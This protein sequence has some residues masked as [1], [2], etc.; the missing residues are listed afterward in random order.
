MRVLG[1][2]IKGKEMRVALVERIDCTA[3]WVNLATKKIPLND[4]DSADEMRQIFDQV[5][6]LLSEH[7]VDCVAVKKRP[8][9]GAM[10]SGG[11]SFRLEAILQLQTKADFRLVTAQRI[12]KLK[13]SGKVEFPKGLNKYQHDAFAA[14]VGAFPE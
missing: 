14:A 8:S 3:N 12:A 4:P 13:D 10:A 2:D 7:H 1:V 5:T 11:D 6:S 9:S